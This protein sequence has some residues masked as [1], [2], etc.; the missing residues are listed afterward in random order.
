MM[1]RGKLRVYLGAAPGVGKT[2]D[3]LGEGQ[4]RAERG[5]DV[6]V[7][8]MEDYGRPLTRKM[9]EGLE[10]VPRK[11]MAYRDCAFTEMDLDAVL[12]RHPQVALVDGLAH[13]NIPGCRNKKRWQDVREDGTRRQIPE[14]GNR[15]RTQTRRGQ[16]PQPAAGLP[17]PGVRQCHRPQ[18]GSDQE[19]V[20]ESTVCATPPGRPGR[21]ARAEAVGRH[22]EL[23]GGEHHLSEQGPTR[24]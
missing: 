19:H 24:L 22:D 6:I 4:R 8:F 10:C 14:A 23:G 20:R 21:R 13:T 3:I 12:A 2:Y 1:V 18:P 11:T 17:R 9:A 7:A 16:H 15:R 5:T